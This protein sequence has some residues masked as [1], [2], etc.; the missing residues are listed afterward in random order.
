MDIVTRL[1]SG[2]RRDL[3][4][5]AAATV[6]VGLFNLS[7]VAFLVAIR[8]TGRAIPREIRTRDLVLAGVATYR[9]SRLLAKDEVTAF[10]RAPFTR[11]VGPPNEAGEVEEEPRGSGLQREIGELL[12]HP[13][14]IGQWV[15]TAFIYGMVLAP[16]VTRLVASVFTASAIADLLQYSTNGLRE[17]ARSNPAEGA[18]AG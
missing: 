15:A 5:V 16:R 6:L 18:Q 4:P 11:L 7:F 2:Y 8:A 12:T 1:Y 13:L 17:S 9:L 10:L 14:S 3:R